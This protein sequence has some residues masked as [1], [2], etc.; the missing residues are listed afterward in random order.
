MKKIELENGA[1]KLVADEGKRLVVT[2]AEGNESYTQEVLI[3]SGVT[4]NEWGEAEAIT[5]TEPTEEENKQQRIAQLEA[6]LAELK[7]E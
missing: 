3:P 2:D 4:L 6:E 5:T 1:Y 7:A